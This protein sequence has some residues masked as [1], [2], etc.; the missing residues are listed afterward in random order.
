MI[1]VI[2]SVFGIHRCKL[3]QTKTLR[4]GF[5]LWFPSAPPSILRGSKT[6]LFFLD[7]RYLNTTFLSGWGAVNSMCVQINHAHS[8]KDAVEPGYVYIIVVYQYMVS[9]CTVVGAEF[10]FFRVRVTGK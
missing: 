10:E 9:T 3:S 8:Y 1:K 6:I 5:L 7:G 2:K 4:E